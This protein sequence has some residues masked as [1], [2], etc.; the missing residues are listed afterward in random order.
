MCAKIIFM[1]MILDTVDGQI[2]VTSDQKLT[3]ILLEGEMLPGNRLVTI[4]IV[5]M[6][7][8]RLV[9]MNSGSWFIVMVPGSQLVTSSRGDESLL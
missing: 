6:S 9:A 1:H 7:G 2:F 4:I 5:M 3:I 8:S